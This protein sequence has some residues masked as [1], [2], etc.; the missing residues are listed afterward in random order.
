MIISVCFFGVC[1]F[2]I[3]IYHYLLHKPELYWSKK[4]QKKSLNNKPIITITE[5]LIEITNHKIQC[6]KHT[7]SS[8]TKRHT[9]V[10]SYCYYSVSWQQL[11][12]VF[13]C[14]LRCTK[15]ST[16]FP[17]FV[18]SSNGRSRSAVTD[19]TQIC[20]GCWQCVCSYLVKKKKLVLFHTNN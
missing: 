3:I 11:V 14:F 17:P 4:T 12:C 15:T 1:F 7:L 13:V 2:F 8:L 18:L 19:C 5:H 16:L 20:E 6:S 9:L 10:A